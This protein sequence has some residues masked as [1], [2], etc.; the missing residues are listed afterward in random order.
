ME[1]CVRN[2]H[3]RGIYMWKEAGVQFWEDCVDSRATDRGG[4][5][6]TGMRWGS[7]SEKGGSKRK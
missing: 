4:D 3:A 7:E 5:Y 6:C 2:L 1:T